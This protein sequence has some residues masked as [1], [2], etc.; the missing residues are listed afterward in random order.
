MSHELITSWLGLPPGGWP[1]DH[2]TLL[3]LPKAEPDVERIEQR[4]H[5]RL[6]RLRQY[7]L[8]HPDQVTEAMNRLA[9]AFTCLTDPE[10]KRAYDAG[11]VGEQQEEAASA[12]QPPAPDREAGV[13]FPATDAAPADPLAW[14]FGPWSEGSLRE[15]SA[16]PAGT[17]QLDWSTSPPASRQAV[18]GV[19]EAPTE[20]L[21]DGDG[22][23]KAPSE[24]AAPPAIDPTTEAAQASPAARRGLGTKRA[25]YYRIART[26][27]LLW[28]WEQAGK[29][30]ANPKRRLT[31]ATEAVELTRQLG[32]IRDRLYRFPPI[33]GG[34]GQR[35]YFVAIL[36]RQAMI[37]PTFRT[38]LSSQREELARDWQAG[39]DIILSHRQFLRRELHALRRKSWLAR[40]LRAARALVNDHPGKVLIVLGAA[41]LLIAL[42]YHFAIQSG[43]G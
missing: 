5:E 42:W 40:L 24:V 43:R 7:Q 25:L 16:T 29:Y 6:A 39:R 32:R 11:L 15:A 33:L 38:L 19:A 35:G 41:A 4:V 21:I 10:A 8:N 18:N 31:K 20:P 13:A 34:A 28:A 27:E 22:P 14:L 9:Q 1:P 2:Y 3:G 23:G 17:A 37:V 12:A 30:L 26:R 36:A